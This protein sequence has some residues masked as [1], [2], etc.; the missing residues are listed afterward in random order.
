VVRKISLVLIIVDPE[1]VPASIPGVVA[2]S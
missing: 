1:D 2:N